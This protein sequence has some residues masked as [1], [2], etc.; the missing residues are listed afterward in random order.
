MD[1]GY[2]F[3]NTIVYGIIALCLSG[4]FSYGKIFNL[5]LWWYFV[6]LAYLLHDIMVGWVSRTSFAMFFFILGS[7][8]LI[9]RV[10]LRFFEHEKQR[11]HVW[12]VMTLWLGAVLENVVN[13]VYGPNSVSF[14]LFHMPV[15]G[16]LLLFVILLGIFYYI[17]GYTT[18][19]IIF[20]W[21]FEKASII[22][23]LGIDIGSLLHKYFLF[24]LLLIA[25]AV[26]LTLNDSAIR[27]SDGLF[28]LIKGIGIMILV[29][30]ENKE[31]MLFGAL[32][33]VLLEYLFFITL[34]FP[35]AYKES[36]VLVIIL[37]VLMV[38]PE[39]LFGRRKRNL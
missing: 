31:Y 11:H 23:G 13:Y 26:F 24:L 3:S 2:V 20:K 16:W 8:F 12:L 25:L 4:F 5:S 33:Y 9:N 38:K 34:W 29:G 6:A 17:F 37:V 39:G 19:W 27:S 15:E 7:Y 36:L 10:L 28:Y 14:S 30:I 35:I 18:L 1:W 21:I 32:F 22:R